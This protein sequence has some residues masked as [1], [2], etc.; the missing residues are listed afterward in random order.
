MEER[1]AANIP[2][3][4]KMFL[5]HSISSHVMC[6]NIHTLSLVVPAEIIDRSLS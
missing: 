2:L 4:S 6:A 1:V 5:E 3:I